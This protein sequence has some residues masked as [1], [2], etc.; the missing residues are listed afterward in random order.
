MNRISI[1]SVSLVAGL[2]LFSTPMYAHAYLD[3]GTGSMF[4]QMLFAGSAGIGALARLAW[5][6]L[7]NRDKKTPLSA[8]NPDAD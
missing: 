4:I 8:L 1:L 7:K 6:R 3:A 2:V 5:N